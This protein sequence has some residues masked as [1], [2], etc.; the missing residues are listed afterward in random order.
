MWGAPSPAFCLE[1]HGNMPSEVG[2]VATARR[3]QRFA[4]NLSVTWVRRVATH[5]GGRFFLGAWS[6]L[7]RRGLRDLAAAP[8]FKAASDPPF[9]VSRQPA[10][11]LIRSVGPREPQS[12]SVPCGSASRGP[13]APAGD[14]PS[15]GG[16]PASRLQL[17]RPRHPPFLPGPARKH[18]RRPGRLARTTRSPALCGVSQASTLLC[19]SAFD[20]KIREAVGR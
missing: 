3:G 17:H 15:R 4:S 7:R 11:Q 19:P 16:L 2:S 18:A 9:S 5:A 1:I 14:P 13:C 20:G 10:M 12:F 6:V 8:A